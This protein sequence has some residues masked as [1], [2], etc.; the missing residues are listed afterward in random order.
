MH[1]KEQSILGRVRQ[2]LRAALLLLLT[3]LSISFGFLAWISGAH[4]I[5]WSIEMKSTEGSA[6]LLKMYIER[7]HFRLEMSVPVGYQEPSQAWTLKP[8]P[9]ARFLQVYSGIN[10]YNTGYASDSSN[11]SHELDVVAFRVFG[12]ATNRL[13]WMVLVLLGGWPL[14]VLTKSTVHK[15]VRWRRSKSNRCLQCGY[16]LMGNTSGR[17]PECGTITCAIPKEVA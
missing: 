15:V 14:L 6:D 10:I 4:A 8:D 16:N 7:P 3:V 17:C 9:Q 11:S 1:P 5:E 12:V 13:W 2:T